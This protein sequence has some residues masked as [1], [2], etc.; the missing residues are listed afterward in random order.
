MISS[1]F[2]N[3]GNVV[4]RVW[5][6]VGT[7]GNSTHNNIVCLVAKNKIRRSAILATGFRDGEIDN[8][9]SRLINPLG[10]ILKDVVCIT[11]S[12]FNTVS[13]ILPSSA[14]IASNSSSSKVF[15]VVGNI[16]PKILIYIALVESAKKK[17]NCYC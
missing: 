12:I 4:A 17:H 9:S 10:D 3:G 8:C 13:L 7:L 1:V 11:N 2:G 5:R 16:E 15:S 14:D 6:S